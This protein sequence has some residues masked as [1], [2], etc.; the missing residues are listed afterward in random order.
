MAI[1]HLGAGDE[2]AARRMSQEGLARA[3]GPHGR[4]AR[5]CLADLASQL[6]G[7]AALQ[8][9]ASRT[10]GPTGWLRDPD[11]LARSVL[12]LGRAHL[13]EAVVE[14]I[15][16]LM[17][18]HDL[19]QLVRVLADAG[20]ACCDDLLVVASAVLD[21]P[22]GLVAARCAEGRAPAS[23]VAQ[24]LARPVAVAAWATAPRDAPDQ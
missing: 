20:S 24:V 8:R 7:E 11:H 14:E 9:F 13:V 22:A 17:P 5:E 19:L 15:G 4:R 16:L 10:P 6:D 1:V 18:D 12:R 23:T 2:V 21:G 3:T